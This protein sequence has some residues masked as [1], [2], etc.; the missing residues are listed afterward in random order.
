MLIT[1]GNAAMV[2]AEL[3]EIY[4]LGDDVIAAALGRARAEGYAEIPAGGFAIR[5]RAVPDDLGN[6]DFRA[7]KDGQGLFGAAG[8]ERADYASRAE[9]VAALTGRHG[10]SAVKAE[11]VARNADE[12]GYCPF[13][14]GGA[15]FCA[16]TYKHR[17][18]YLIERDDG[19][20]LHEAPGLPDSE[21][22]PQW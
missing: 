14:A 22:G 5:V 10:M 20:P 9:L 19:E 1:N 15:Q 2:S 13:I 11:Y 18:G 17:D 7:D 4:R 16:G 21:H 12:A 8:N 6:V 3:R